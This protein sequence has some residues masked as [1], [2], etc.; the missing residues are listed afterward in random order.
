MSDILV[1]RKETFPRLLFEPSKFPG[2]W[3]KKGRVIVA[4][5]TE[6][7]GFDPDGSSADPFVLR[8]DPPGPDPSQPVPRPVLSV[9]LFR[10][11]M[12]LLFDDGGPP[13][14]R[15]AI[16]YSDSFDGVTE[17]S[18]VN[19]TRAKHIL[20]TT[21]VQGVLPRSGPERG[22]NE[23]FS[24]VWRGAPVNKWFGYYTAFPGTL[25]LQPGQMGR[26]YDIYLA[27]TEDPNGIE[28]WVR[29]GVVLSPDAT[30]GHWEGGRWETSKG[31]V[32]GGLS[33]PS[34]LWDASNGQFLMWYANLE[35]PLGT[36]GSPAI[37]AKPQIGLARSTDVAGKVWVKEPNPVLRLGQ[38][39]EWDDATVTHCH[40]VADPAGG[41]HMFYHGNGSGI[42]NRTGLG[43][44]YSADG[45]HWTKNPGNPIVLGGPGESWDEQVLGPS[46]LILGKVWR[47]YYWGRPILGEGFGKAY[48]GYAEAPRVNA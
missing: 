4:G 37:G 14:K 6:E 41:F 5:G 8:L 26:Y 44:A 38:P 34:V 23:T 48:I 31:N 2:P 36:L 20:F 46:A 15:Q 29:Q 45:V 25:Q 40:V 47:L 17:W 27:T 7:T 16:A 3:V 22:G 18:A 39:G 43:H 9:P 1:R 21:G 28:E 24:A 12:S 42:L 35:R 13:P 30:P 10:M 32:G 19:G 33:E 11:W